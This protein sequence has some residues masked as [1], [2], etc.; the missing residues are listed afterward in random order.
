MA[1]KATEVG[2][3]DIVPIITERTI[4]TGLK[5]ARLQK[6]AAE[7]AEQSGRGVVPTVHK[8]MTFKQALV[9]CA[10]N[11]VNY[12]LIHQGKFTING[13]TLFRD[14]S[15]YSSALKAGG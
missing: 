4:K 2:V 9:D 1:Q 3:H 10:R 13:L 12:F 5:L 15:D 14:P 6:I 11:D 8:A 7:A